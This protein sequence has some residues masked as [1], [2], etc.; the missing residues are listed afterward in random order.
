[1]YGCRWTQAASVAAGRAKVGLRPAYGYGSC[2]M[3][4]AGLLTEGRDGADDAL[5]GRLS[6]VS[7]KLVQLFLQ[8]VRVS[9]PII[10]ALLQA[11]M[12]RGIR[13]NVIART[14]R[15][16]EREPYERRGNRTFGTK[17]E[18]RTSDTQH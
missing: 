16:V 11:G 1:V 6:D 14:F 5:S 3:Y 2:F 17:R 18:A 7:K 4:T 10:A 12:R 8:S 15:S 13:Y 9:R